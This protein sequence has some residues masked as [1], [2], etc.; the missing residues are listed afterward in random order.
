MQ[1]LIDG[2]FDL[3]YH[4]YQH[5]NVRI[6]NAVSKQNTINY[7]TLQSKL[8]TLELEQF[9]LFWGNKVDTQIRTICSKGSAVSAV[10]VYIGDLHR[11]NSNCSSF[12]TY[13]SSL[14]IHFVTPKQL[15]LLNFQNT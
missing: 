8:Y 12:R 15:K 5:L 7:F 9:E 11:N 4:G 13:R 6:P 10:L 3:G 14:G 2:L 1:D